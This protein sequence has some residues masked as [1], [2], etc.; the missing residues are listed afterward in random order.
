[1]RRIVMWALLACAWVPASAAAGQPFGLGIGEHPSANV[2][3]RSGARDPLRERS[4]ASAVGSAPAQ[5]DGDELLSQIE[6][7][8]VDIPE[9][10]DA[11]QVVTPP[12][13]GVPGSEQP[14]QP[15]VDQPED[16]PATAPEPSAPPPEDPGE[17]D[18]GED[19]EEVRPPHIPDSDLEDG[20]QI[21][22]TSTPAR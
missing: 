6:V 1:M 2:A 18:E 15:K 21:H 10:P 4:R 17:G 3:G 14:R 19:E 7:P 16:P 22:E 20:P 11:S 5:R 8:D 9:S 12:P 13:D